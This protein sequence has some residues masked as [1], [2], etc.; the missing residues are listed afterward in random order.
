MQCPQLKPRWLCFNLS[1]FLGGNWVKPSAKAARETHFCPL[2]LAL[3][4]LSLNFLRELFADPGP[5]SSR[6]Q[7]AGLCQFLE[8]VPF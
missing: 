8:L 4:S 6:D 7:P 1:P 2:V 5:H 3:T